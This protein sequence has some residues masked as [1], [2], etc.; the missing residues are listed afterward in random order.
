MRAKYRLVTL[1]CKV[2]QYESQVV[3]ELL[4][5]HGCQ[6]A[7]PG[8]RADLAIVNTCAV[9][10]AA[11]R[12]SRYLVRR[13][14]SGGRTRVVVVGCGA[15]AERQRLAGID[16]VEAV[17]GH[18]RDVSTVLRDL[19]TDWFRRIGDPS[20]TGLN[21]GPSESA[22]AAPSR[23]RDERNEQNM[24]PVGQLDRTRLDY[25]Q[26]LSTKTNKSMTQSLALVKENDELVTQIHQFEGHRRAFLKVQDGCD[27]CCTYCIIPQLRPMLR[28]KPVPVAVEEARGLVA[29]GF[30]EI[31][32]T[33]VFL[34]AYG[35]ETAVRK[36]FSQAGSPLARLVNAL[37]QIDGL[38]RLRLSSL[39]P[40]DMDGDLL[41]SLAGHPVCVPHLH[42][43]LQSGSPEILRRMNRQ[44]T[45]EQFVA[46]I[47]RVRAVLDRPAISTDIIV[48]FPGESE[49]DF[50]DSLRVARHAEFVK[51]HAFP[52]SPREGTAAAK[53]SRQF[54]P[55]AVVAERMQRLGELES[56]SSLRFRSRFVGGVERVVVEEDDAKLEPG[57]RE[58]D[59]D[60]ESGDDFAVMR[61]GRSSRYFAV[62]FEDAEAQPG[63]VVDVRIDR[64]TPRRTHG[65]RLHPGRR[66]VRLPV[67]S[68]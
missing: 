44:Y 5:A 45:L 28:S 51:I 61:H 53:G 66:L 46:M 48:G 36:R 67:L 9:T 17:I 18:D 26:R 57:E 14:A 58:D 16:G 19:L 10:A 15:V 64:V 24:S 30:R 39:E 37:A 22:G 62:H 54:V 3:R 21:T 23:R 7:S 1:G 29:A 11:S 34:G 27:A 25:P 2:N 42:L 35:R 41:E 6:T 43:P 50:A 60:F 32:L 56:E 13:L 8:E 55:Q 59:G 38:L 33:G 31:V 63:E 52:F 47:D 4:E 40:G 12:K 68:A 20:A 65:S 49:Q